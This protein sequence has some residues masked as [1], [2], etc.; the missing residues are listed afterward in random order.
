MGEATSSSGKVKTN[1][2]AEMTG[3]WLPTM[4]GVPVSTL[5]VG[6]DSEQSFQHQGER[7]GQ[8]GPEGGGQ[9]SARGSQ[10]PLGGWDDRP[11][12]LAEV[13][14]P[15]DNGSDIQLQFDAAAIDLGVAAAQRHQGCLCAK[16]F[17]VSAAVAWEEARYTKVS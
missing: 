17:N 11:H 2:A 9:G 7:A 10:G 6:E 15:Q 1:D 16:C 12:G 3:T 8:Q 5:S 13:A 14:R 4:C